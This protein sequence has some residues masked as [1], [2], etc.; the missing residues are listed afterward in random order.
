[1]DSAVCTLGKKRTLSG[2]VN[3]V[4]GLAVL[5][6]GWTF[7]EIVLFV[8]GVLIAIKGVTDLIRVLNHKKSKKGVLKLLFPCLTIALGVALALGNG[9][10]MV[11]M[12]IGILLIIDGAI[13]LISN[14]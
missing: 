4:I 9:F 13:G 6:L 2:A 5:V 1:M 12:G 14:R 8:L 7:V 11:I 3:L 10:D